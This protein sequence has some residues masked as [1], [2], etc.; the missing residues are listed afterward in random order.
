MTPKEREQLDYLC[1]RIVSEKDPQT[2][3]RLVKELEALLEAK[4]ERLQLMRHSGSF[5][6]TAKPD[7]PTAES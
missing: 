4:H 3:D 5:P 2:F 7:P 1:K 6:A